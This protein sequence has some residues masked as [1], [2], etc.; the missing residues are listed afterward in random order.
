MN[1][2]NEFQNILV[3][4][5]ETSPDLAIVD[6]A[7]QFAQAMNSELRGLFVEDVNL[8]NFAGLPNTRE[9]TFHT[10]RRQELTLTSLEERLSRTARNIKRHLEQVAGSRGLSWTFDVVRGEL[11]PE[12]SKAAR[13]C[14]LLVLNEPDLFLRQDRAHVGLQIV[15]SNVACNAALVVESRS[16]IG[17]GPVMAIINSDHDAGRDYAKAAAIAE[18]LGRRLIVIAM[19]TLETKIDDGKGIKEDAAPEQ[20]FAKAEMISEFDIGKIATMAL[21][22]K[23]GLLML[24]GRGESSETLKRARELFRFLKL[25]LLILRDV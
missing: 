9:V 22:E 23:A 24:F 11:S 2:P 15:Y 1:A 8:V 3:A 13:S 19:G 16:G 5:D 21:E 10:V 6:I 17:D 4:I 20:G 18:G 12:L 14:D 7:A 25:P